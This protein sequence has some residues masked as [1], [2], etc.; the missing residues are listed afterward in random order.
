MSKRA[1]NSVRV[2]QSRVHILQNIFIKTTSNNGRTANKWAPVIVIIAIS[3]A[4]SLFTSGYLFFCSVFSYFACKHT[5]EYQKKN[6]RTIRWFCGG[7]G[8]SNN[9]TH[10]TAAAGRYMYR[11]RRACVL[12]DIYTCAVAP[13]TQHTNKFN[14]FQIAKQQAHIYTQTQARDRIRAS[15]C[16]C[17]CAR[18]RAMIMLNGVCTNEMAKL[19]AIERSNEMEMSRRMCTIE[20]I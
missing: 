15:V 20:I 4:L 1:H 13:H 8:S 12:Y 9:A 17:M 5:K 11:R 6:F 16:A 14:R 10:N 7:G 2:E 18:G 3:L 19:T